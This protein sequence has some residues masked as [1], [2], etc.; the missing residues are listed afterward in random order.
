MSEE[1][2]PDRDPLLGEQRA[3]YRAPARL[4]QLGRGAEMHR[5]EH[6][7]IDGSAERA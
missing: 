3:Y 2:S 5:T 7:F 4:R 6:Y 1:D